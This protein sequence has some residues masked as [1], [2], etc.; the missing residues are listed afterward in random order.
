VP[1]PRATTWPCGYNEGPAPL[2]SDYVVVNSWGCDIKGEHIVFYA[3]YV[4]HRQSQGFI[5]AIA[6]SP[7]LMKTGG[8]TYFDPPGEGAIKIVGFQDGAVDVTTSGGHRLAFQIPSAGYF[9]RPEGRD[10]SPRH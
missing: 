5:V 7:N 10:K 9:L 8:H 6:H 1:T 2:D 3:G 4:R